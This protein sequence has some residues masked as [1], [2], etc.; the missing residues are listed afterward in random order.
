MGH[1]VTILVTSQH[2]RAR[3]VEGWQDGVRIIQTPDLF[4]GSL[5]SGWDPWNTIRRIEWLRNQTMDLVHAFE[6]RPTVIYPALFLHQNKHVP[7]VM[8]W[9]DWFGKGGSVEQRKNPVVRTVLRPIETYFEEYFRNKADATTVICS[10]LLAKAVHVGV[11]E[12]S[13]RLIYNGCSTD[14]ALIDHLTARQLASMPT[15][16]FLIGYVG[17]IFLNDARLMA[18]AFDIVVDHHPNV[19]LVI[20]GY[21]PFDFREFTRYPQAVFQTGY[22]EPGALFH[23]LCACDLFW[24]PMLDSNANRGRFPLK[25]NDYLSAGRPCVATAVGDVPGLLSAQPVGL[26]CEAT[27]EALAHKTITL[28][29]DESLRLRLGMNARKAAEGIWNWSKKTEELE[30]VYL[31]V[32]SDQS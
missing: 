23:T 20:A 32:L 31:K 10:E 17:S 14:Q 21:F 18:K 1:Q 4:R 24:L 3:M 25:L 15:D 29:E 8:D 2:N 9:A 30:Q 5:R 28:F 7:L 26:V 11:P 12:R 16:G 22:L 6:S 19:R 13:I 27:P